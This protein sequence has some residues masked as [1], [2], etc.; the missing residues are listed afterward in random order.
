M[1]QAHPAD[2]QDRDGAILL[3]KASRDNFQLVELAF[4]DGADRLEEATSF[5]LEIVKK[6]ANHVGFQVLP[7]R[8]VVERT[9]AWINCN[10]RLAKGGEATIDSAVAFLYA[11]SVML[12]TRRLV[13][14]A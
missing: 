12:L 14:P 4:A 2:I 11:T 9:L 1:I 10:R 5:T 3:L 7:R 8:C 13:R 6:I